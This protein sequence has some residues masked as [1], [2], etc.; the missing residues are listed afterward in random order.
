M[1]RNEIIYCK[2]FARNGS[3]LPLTGSQ[4]EGGTNRTYFIR[5][6]RLALPRALI[7]LSKA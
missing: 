6:N 7:T 2:Y 1:S 3:A 5:L 4:R